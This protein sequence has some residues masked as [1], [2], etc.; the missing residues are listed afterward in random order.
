MRQVFFIHIMKTGG[1]SF[2][3]M[4]ER[5]LGESLYPRQKELL[6]NRKGWYLEGH[7]LL[8]A[9][10]EGT[11]DLRAR[12][13]VCGHYPYV[14]GAQLGGNLFYATF[15]RDP[16]ARTISMIGHARRAHRGR[17]NK[18][19]R[20]ILADREIVKCQVENYQTKVLAIE[21]H[22]HPSVNASFPIDRKA[23]RLAAERLERLDFV[24]LNEKFSASLKHF[25]RV[26]GIRF[27]GEIKRSNVG[28]RLHVTAEERRMIEELVPF[29]IELYRLAEERF[30]ADT[31]SGVGRA[32]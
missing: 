3:R 27:S 30:R 13:V 11:L 2:R 4:L 5:E 12:R 17:R 23:F 19:V 9:L 31:S 15:L 1:T 10:R 28:E 26:T 29:D 16:V 18:S 24:G 20:E 25:S 22:E 7:Q 6:A 21:S 8:E 32:R 14:L